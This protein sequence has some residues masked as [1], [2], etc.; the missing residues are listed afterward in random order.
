MKGNCTGSQKIP[1]LLLAAFFLTGCTEQAPAESQKIESIPE[2]SHTLETVGTA[3]PELAFKTLE[4]GVDFFLNGEHLQTIP[5]ERVPDAEEII[6]C[7]YDSDGFPDL[8][9]PEWPYGLRGYYY[10]YDNTAGQLVLWDELNFIEDSMGWYMEKQQDGTLLM[11]EYSHYGSASTTY[12]WGQDVLIPAELEE[13]YFI[14]GAAVTDHYSYTEE[15]QKIL[16]RREVTDDSSGQTEATEYPLYFRVLPETVQVLKGAEVLQELPVN[17]FWDGYASLGD[18]FEQPSTTPMEG[19]YLREPEYYLGT[20]DY[21][22]DGYTDL[23]IPDSLHGEFVGTYYR[24]EL[25]SEQYVLWEELNAIGHALY[26]NTES[27]CLTAYFG[28]DGQRTPQDYQWN[29]GHLIPM[30]ETD[31]EG[32]S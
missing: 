31:Q 13:H 11:T 28:T 25:E 21:D 2:T 26:I 27:G 19:A 14:S 29:E 30:D 16:Y 5:M 3:A 10:R 23:Y 18:F 6:I 9:L 15:G 32:T 7:D 20:E 1:L 17:D 12:R 22:F 24:Y 8:F 4:N